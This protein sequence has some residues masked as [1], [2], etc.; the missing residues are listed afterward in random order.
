MLGEGGDFEEVRKGVRATSFFFF[1]FF[2]FCG[3]VW[4]RWMRLV[5]YKGKG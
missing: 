5:K 4:D 1:F 2:F 3:E